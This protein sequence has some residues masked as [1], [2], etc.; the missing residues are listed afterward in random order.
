[1]FPYIIITVIAIGI[2]FLVGANADPEELKAARVNVAFVELG[3]HRTI[4]QIYIDI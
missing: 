4:L 2:Y 1:M 3:Q